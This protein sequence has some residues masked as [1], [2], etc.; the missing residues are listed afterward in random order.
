LSRSLEDPPQKK[1]QK[2]SKTLL[3]RIKR[4]V[5]SFENLYNG[6]I[7]INKNIAHNIEK[8]A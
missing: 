3:K 8:K 1:I 5:L 7:K 2:N 4:A 6:R